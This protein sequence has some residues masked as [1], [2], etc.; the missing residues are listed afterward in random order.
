MLDGVWDAIRSVLG[1]GVDDLS[2]AQM[3]V[4]AVLTFAVAVAILRL[5]DKRLLGK[6]TAF[7]NVVAIMIGSILSGAITGSTPLFRTWL[8]GMALVGL[9]WLVAYLAY[10]DLF[11]PLV[12]GNPVLLVE[13]GE[14]REDAMRESHVSRRDLEQALRNSGHDPDPSGVRRAHLERDGSISVVPRKRGPQVVEVSVRAGVQT[15]RIALE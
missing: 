15:V 8:A 2:A 13:D 1:Y 10:L 4:R 9:H 6:G 5:G 7:D 12:K 14:I 11:G 3:V